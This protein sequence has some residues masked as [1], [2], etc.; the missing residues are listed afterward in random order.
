MIRVYRHAEPSCLAPVRNR[1]LAKLRILE[2]TR[3]V[4]GDD[5]NREAYRVVAEILWRRQHL[6]CCYCERMVT[7]LFN[8]VEHFRPKGRAM[9]GPGCTEQHGYYWL[10]FTWQN[11]LF[12]CDVCNRT[13]KNDLFPLDAGSVAL[14][15][16]EDPPGNEKPL[17]VDPA[18]EDAIPHIVFVAKTRTKKRPDEQTWRDVY[19]WEAEPRAGSER[20]GRSIKVFGLNHFQFQDLYLSHV[21]YNLNDCVEAIRK[22]IKNNDAPR[23]QEEVER[24]RLRHFTRSV[25]YVGL[26]Y[27]ALR[28]FVPDSQLTPFGASWPQPHK[29][30]LAPPQRRVRARST[31]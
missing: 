6:K 19:R 25:V 29:V 7:A 17:L 18:V 23:V 12:A 9:R 4:E 24:A 10:A 3:P 11:L 14:K 21:R 27:D 31:P 2:T 13:G 1:E 8:D 20:G 30:S 28:Y 5:I 22:A 26:S 15:A 16:W